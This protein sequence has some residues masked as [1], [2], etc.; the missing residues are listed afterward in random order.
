[1][2]NKVWMVIAL[3]EAVL[4]IAG[5]V[6]STITIRNLKFDLADSE[7]EIAYLNAEDTDGLNGSLIKDGDNIIAVKIKWPGHIFR[8]E[9]ADVII[10]DEEGNEAYHYHYNLFYGYVIEEIKLEKY[11]YPEQFPGWS[12]ESKKY[13]S[14]C[15]VD[16]EGNELILYLP[17]DTYSGYDICAEFLNRSVPV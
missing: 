6:F 17:P 12:D 13:E 5:V 8:S 11:E 15:D 16:G 7:E 3:F 14:I 9:T 2:K 4:I 10:K 1:M